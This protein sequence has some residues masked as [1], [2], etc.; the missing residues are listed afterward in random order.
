MKGLNKFLALVMVTALVF[1]PLACTNMN[2]TLQGSVSG[3]AGGALVGAIIG[4]IAGGH[5]GAAVGAA[6]GGAA[7]E[8]AGVII[9]N[10]QEQNEKGYSPEPPVNSYYE[11]G[12]R[13]EQGCR[14]LQ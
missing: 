9:G 10:T 13:Y 12:Y 8:L 11:Q 14:Q 2:K 5:N 4:A 1:G 7:G 3:A 6:I